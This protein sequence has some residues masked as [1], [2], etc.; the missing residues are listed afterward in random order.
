MAQNFDQQAAALM[1]Q[2]LR[3]VAQHRRKPQL[4][5]PAGVAPVGGLTPAVALVVAQLLLGTLLRW[6]APC[7]AQ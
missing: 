5:A 4:F 2:H 3:V 1:E 6:A 7:A